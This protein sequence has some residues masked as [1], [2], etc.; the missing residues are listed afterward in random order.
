MRAQLCFVFD[1]LQIRFST[2]EYKQAT[3]IL[4]S[5]KIPLNHAQSSFIIIPPRSTYISP[6]ILSPIS[7]FLVRKITRNFVF[8]PHR[9]SGFY[10]DIGSTYTKLICI[11]SSILERSLNTKDFLVVLGGDREELE[12]EKGVGGVGSR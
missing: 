11:L 1:Y 5:Y 6:T 4:R 10:Q 12:D 3:P 9:T 8:Q 7:F 2:P